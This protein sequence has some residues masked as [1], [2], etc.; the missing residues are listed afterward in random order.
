MRKTL[1]QL[2]PL[3][4]VIAEKMARG[5]GAQALGS[6]ISTPGLHPR[7]VEAYSRNPKDALATA[8]DSLMSIEGPDKKEQLNSGLDAYFDLTIKLD[9]AAFPN[10]ASGEVTK[11]VPDY[12]P[13]GFIDMGKDGNIAPDQRERE[14]IRVDKR[15][16][17][18]KYKPFIADVLG[19][20]YGETDK[21]AFKRRLAIEAA[22]EVYR[23]MQYNI[24][25]SENL[26]GDIVD[27]ST[28]PEG[29][30][31][32]QGL[33]FQVLCQTLGLKSRI[34]KSYR[35]GERHSTNMVRFDGQWYIFDVTNPDYAVNSDG[36]KEWRPG[37]FAVDEPPK[38]NETKRYEVKG[39][40]SGEAHTYTAHDKMFW[41]VQADAKAA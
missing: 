2:A 1:E 27:L 5:I 39:R 8:R 24:S 28:V 26:G 22:K 30:C 31:R 33:I 14:Q 40:F 34:L 16:I 4:T 12:I 35:D 10:S 41:R 29:V 20:D 7:L 37:A 25:S 18:E 11:G 17:L 32:H 38:P 23:S 36:D 13:D 9:H 15:E 21:Q 19:R 3:E 6:E